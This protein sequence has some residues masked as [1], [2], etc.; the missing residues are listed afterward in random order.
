M[1]NAA[2]DQTNGLVV[3][4]KKELAKYEL[5]EYIDT[6]DLVVA[7]QAFVEIQG[8]TLDNQEL[9]KQGENL[10]EYIT[11]LT[12]KKDEKLQAYYQNYSEPMPLPIMIII[13]LSTIIVIILIIKYF[14]VEYQKIEYENNYDP[15]A[16]VEAAPA[17]NAPNADQQ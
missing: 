17:E 10:K 4:S 2:K 9:K 7:M 14:I 8:T 5:Y 1:T 13:G 16:P 6:L 3:F 15:P 11:S 12:K